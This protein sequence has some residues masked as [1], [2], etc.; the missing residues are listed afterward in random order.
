MKVLV[1]LIL[2]TEPVVLPFTPGL[3]CSAQGEAWIEANATYINQ[4]GTTDQGW[5]TA[6]DKLVYAYYCE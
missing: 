6:E 2:L 5:Y 1:I 4:S 3:S